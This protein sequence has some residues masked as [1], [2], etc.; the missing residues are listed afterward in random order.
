MVIEELKAKAGFGGAKVEIRIPKDKYRLDETIKGEVLLSGGKVIQRIQTLNIRLIREWSTESYAMDMAVA[1]LPTGEGV[2]A[3][4]GPHRVRVDSQYELV[5]DSGKDTLA[6][7]ELARNINIQS[8]EK[9]IFP[10]E[11]NLLEIRKKEGASEKWKLQ[12]RADIPYAK[13]AVAECEVKIA[14]QGKIDK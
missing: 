11:I 12:A 13:D 8:E 2:G 10:F 9:I 6:N 5:G 3:A 1:K 14:T 7:I 4:L